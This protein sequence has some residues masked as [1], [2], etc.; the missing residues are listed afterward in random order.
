M[1]EAA[2]R[3]AAE[4]GLEGVSFAVEDAASLT[5]ADASVDGV[6]CRWGLML[7]PDIDARRG[8]D[9]ARSPAGRASRCR[10]VGRPGR[11][12]LDDRIGPERARAGPHGAARPRGAGPVQALRRRQPRRAARGRGPRGRGRRGR[13]ADLACSLARGVVGHHAGHVAD[14]RAAPPA[15][16]RRR[17]P[18]RCDV[19]PSDAWS[20]TSSRTARS[21]SRAS[22]ASRSPCDPADHPAQE[23]MARAGLEPAT[24]RFSAVCSTN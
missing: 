14:A 23:G 9:R 2:R 20:A 6:L 16:H 11:E 12:R 13:P 19:G 7:V 24:P 17:R 15:A 21:P 22:R 1:L 10:G 5:L 3:R 8:R 18:R 4:L